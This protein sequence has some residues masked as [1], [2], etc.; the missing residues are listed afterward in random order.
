[1]ST[2]AAIV[3]VSFVFLGLFLALLLLLYL[4][5]RADRAEWE[6]LAALQTEAPLLFSEEML[7]GPFCQQG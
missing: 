4:D 3:V 7:V 1:V 5:K 2:A 6:R